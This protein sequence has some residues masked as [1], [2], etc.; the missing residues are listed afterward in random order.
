VISLVGSTNS[1]L[2]KCSNFILDCS[3][4]REACHLGLAPTASSTA[5]MAM[6]DA[7]AIAVAE[8]KGFTAEDFK[9][10]HPGGER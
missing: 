6:G 5:A 10:L 7:L 9:R 8:Q 4:E 1:T 2:A 3:V